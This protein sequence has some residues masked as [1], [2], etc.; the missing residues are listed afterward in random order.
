VDAVL[1]GFDGSRIEC[2]AA[3]HL[4]FDETIRGEALALHRAGHNELHRAA[5]LAN[6]LANLYAE[7]VAA[8]K[9]SLDGTPTR[10]IRA[11]G[12]HGQTVRHAPDQGYTLQ[13]NNPALLAEL[14]GIDVVADFR[15][16][17]IAAGGQGAPLVPAFHDAMFRAPTTHRVILNI[18]G[19]ANLTDLAPGRPTT[20]FDCGPGNMLLDAWTQRHLGRP[21]DGTANGRGRAALFPRCAIACCRM[22][23]LPCR[24]RELRPRAVQSGLASLAIDGRRAANVQA[25]LVALTATA[26]G[27]AVVVVPDSRQIYA[28]GGGARSGALMSALAELL[29]GCRRIA[30]RLSWP[31]GRQVEPRLSPG[32]PGAPCIGSPA[33]CPPSPARADRAY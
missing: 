20:G 4:A 15:G 8:L 17:D 31:A 2:L 24:R 29:P 18:G 27:A 5:L 21:F 3:H 26:I 6:R 23:S 25:T 9:V 30:R 32:L 11:I 33:T 1:V 12:C 22:P 28:C 10:T 16:R 7:A 19:I 13:L 14:T